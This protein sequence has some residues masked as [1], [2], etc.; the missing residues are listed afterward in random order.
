MQRSMTN[1]VPAPFLI[2]VRVRSP[3]LDYDPLQDPGPAGVSIVEESVR[4]VAQWYRR[5]SV[6][7]VSERERRRFVNPL[8]DLHVEWTTHTGDLAACLEVM[9]RLNLDQALLSYPEAFCVKDLTLPTSLPDAMLGIRA[10]GYRSTLWVD[11]HL[12]KSLLSTAVSLS[13]SVGSL[14]AAAAFIAQL[15]PDSFPGRR[16]S[17]LTATANTRATWILDD[18]AAARSFFD[19][20]WASAQLPTVALAN[21]DS[22]AVRSVLF[23]CGTSAHS[24]AEEVM[25]RLAAE[26]HAVGVR[27][28]L[29]IP[30]E[31]WVSQRFRAHGGEVFCENVSYARATPQNVEYFRL[32]FASTRPAI[33]HGTGPCGLAASIAAFESGYPFLYHVHWLSFQHIGE[34][35]DWATHIVACSNTARAAVIDFGVHP[36]RV[37]V[38]RNGVSVGTSST[39]DDS[40]KDIDVLCLARFS[41]EKRHDVLIRAVRKVAQSRPL[42][43]VVCVGDD[44]G[45]LTTRPAVEAQIA[46]MGLEDVVRCVPFQRDTAAWLERARILVLT[47]DTEAGP[48]VI[49][50]ALAHGVAVA[51]SRL[52]A[53]E[54]ILGDSGAAALFPRGNVD[55]CADALE[56]LLSNVDRRAALAISGRARVTALYEQPRCA[57]EMLNLMTS[58]ACGHPGVVSST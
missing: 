52:P 24:G 32:L 16:V 58:V 45:P 12:L 31:G 46:Q 43:R 23:V 1:L 2:R 25:L 55:A 4:R 15:P 20:P 36:D 29:S 50:E 9:E 14:Y 18:R 11:Q 48:L 57:Q 26:L 13:A 3:S 54:E 44:I 19:R 6:L 28:M 17:R 37:S 40:S 56:A 35:M 8:R 21:G 7:V 53:T 49:L 33:I 5:A 27:T 10:A 38:V 39:V 42:L 34:E 51:A 47:S 41:S 30:L 22:P